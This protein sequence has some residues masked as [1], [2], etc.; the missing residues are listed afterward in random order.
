MNESRELAI[1]RNTTGS[2]IDL[3]ILKVIWKDLGES[4]FQH[5][6]RTL[7][8]M[9]R[10]QLSSRLVYLIDAGYLEIGYTSD[11]FRLTD[12]GKYIVAE[13]GERTQEAK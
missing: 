1:K 10:R 4:S 13:A 6:S 3:A 8:W 5:L 2:P 7:R 12:T 9:G 11:Q